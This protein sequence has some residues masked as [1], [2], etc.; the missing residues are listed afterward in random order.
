MGSGEG[1]GT[2]RLDV[3]RIWCAYLICLKLT[4]IIA[5]P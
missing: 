1:S 5:Y 2:G 4:K 3:G